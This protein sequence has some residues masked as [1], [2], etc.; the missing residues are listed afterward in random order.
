MQDHPHHYHRTDD[1]ARWLALFVGPNPS[2]DL[3]P[4]AS[5]HSRTTRR[6][7]HTVP[8]LVLILG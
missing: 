3:R 1:W 2:A 8:L 7:R 5:P 6:R 4:L